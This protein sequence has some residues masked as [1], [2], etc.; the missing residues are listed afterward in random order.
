MG[1]DRQTRPRAATPGR[2]PL[3]DRAWPRYPA[4]YEINTWVWLETLSLR[5]GRPVTLA[6]VP[7]E[8]WDD[9]GAVGFDAV[10][11]MG[12]WQ[13]SPAGTA[14]ANENAALL[15]DFRR[16]LPDFQ[17]EDNVGSPYCVPRLRRGRPTRRRDAPAVARR[18]PAPGLALMLDFV[19]NHVAPRPSVGH[20]APAY[21]VRGQVDDVR[22]DPVSFVQIGQ[23]V[24][25]PRPRSLLPGLGPMCCS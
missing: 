19:P 13:R 25:C 12:V 7:D 15:E 6:S 17:P 21:F 14:I 18:A 2:G 16:A 9:I 22:N 20:A 11:L 10:W 5:C 3:A 23:E 24:V 8:A 4:I 1:T